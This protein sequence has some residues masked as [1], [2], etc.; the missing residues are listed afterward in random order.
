MLVFLHCEYRAYI[1]ANHLEWYLTEM[2]AFV[3]YLFGDFTILFFILQY[4]YLHLHSMFIHRFVLL[5]RA[6]QQT[7]E[8][9]RDSTHKN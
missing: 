6:S 9:S 7:R 8:D 2:Q 4:G 1:G 3:Y 5:M